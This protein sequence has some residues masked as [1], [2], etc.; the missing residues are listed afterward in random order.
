M[1]DIRDVVAD[2]EAV[3]ALCVA[4][5]INVD[6]D[7]IVELDGLRRSLIGAVDE[8]RRQSKA[9]SSNR[10]RDAS[11]HEA[12]KRIRGEERELTARLR[13]VTTDLAELQDWLPN[14]LDDRVPIG[15]EEATQVVRLVGQPR[16]YSFEPHP[17]HIVGQRLGIVEIEGAVRAA[18][19]RFY[20]FI[21][22]AVNLRH[23]LV[24]MFTRHVRSQGF[25]L[26]SPPTLAKSDT[27]RASGY[28]P[29]Q[30]KDNFALRDEALSLIGTS[31]QAI[32]GMHMGVTLQTLPVAYLGDSMCYRTEAG[33]YGRDTAGI[34]RAHQFYKL[35]QFV[36]CHPDDSEE[37]FQQC[38]ANEEWLLQELGIPYQ[39]VCTAAG[40]LGAPAMIKFD[41]EAWF[42]SQRKY[43]ELTSN[44]NLGDFQARRGGISFKIGAEKGV[45]HTISATAFTDRLILAV[46]ETYQQEDGSVLL[47]PA[48]EP[49][50]DDLHLKG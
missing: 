2:K 50:F 5:G 48:L 31:E 11:A 40:D 23:A 42:P 13:D 30:V 44:S 20:A 3:R 9:L 29:F 43:R 33:N 39:V 1:V 24:Q 37:W 4:R 16:K 21:D 41:T 22:H 46:L 10:S 28:L 45:P 49:W 17:A 15:G 12:A 19:P 32:L 8:L 6:V 38:L 25:R 14:R 36:F 26:I 34:L 35:E 27:L 47:P 18:Q 7:R